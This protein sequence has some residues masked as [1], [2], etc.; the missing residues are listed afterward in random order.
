MDLDVI[1]RVRV[2]RLTF[3]SDA[4][5]VIEGIGV[6]LGRNILMQVVGVAVFGRQDTDTLW[7]ERNSD[8]S[9]QNCLMQEN[10]MHLVLTETGLKIVI[11]HQP[12][13]MCEPTL[14]QPFRW[15]DG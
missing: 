12:F 13:K 4:D 8:Q 3:V 1:H 11:K 10:S 15:I 6:A 5:K 2:E 14:E 7:S 9:A